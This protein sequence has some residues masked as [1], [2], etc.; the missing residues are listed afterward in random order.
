MSAAALIATT[1]GCARRPAQY[2]LLTP[3][4][5]H[6]SAAPAGSSNPVAASAPPQKTE[7]EASVREDARRTV[8]QRLPVE[9][10]GDAVVVVPVTDEK[11]PL[12][13]AAHGAG[14]TPQ[15]QCQH[16]GAVARGRFL[17]LCPRGLPL[18]RGDDSAFYYPDHH[19]LE[20]EVMA[21]VR[22]ARNT[23]GAQLSS[24]PGVY[25]GY[26]QGATMGALMVIDHGAEFQHLLLVEGGSGDW[27]LGRARRYRATGGKSVAIVCGTSG[28]ASRGQRSR[29]VLERAG[30]RARVEHA[31]GGGHTYTGSVG[32]RA[33][34][35]LDAW[36]LNPD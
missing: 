7:G 32:E 16:W 2:E 30:L 14:D 29:D 17:V 27:T 12:L 10:F 15:W 34:D 4:E 9:G 25:T 21:A 1:A 11:F 31:E 8:T 19:A 24:E 35:L 22:A 13:V 26:S 3:A 33:R 20:R 6:P 5:T 36:L 23:F 28:C 18:V